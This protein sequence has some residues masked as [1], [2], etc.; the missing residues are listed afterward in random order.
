MDSL[1]S[2]LLSWPRGAAVAAIT[3]ASIAGS[4]AATALVVGFVHP[5]PHWLSS[6][7]IAVLIPSL[8]APLVS[9][10]V[11]GMM[12]DLERARAEAIK[13]A[14]TDQL[15]GTLNRRRFMEIAEAQFRPDAPDSARIAVILLDIDNFKMVN[16]VHGHR[17]GDM[18]LKNVA[19]LCAEGLR[20]ADHLARWGGEEFV[21]LLP[22]AGTL[23][24][25]GIAQRLCAAINGASMTV[26]GCPVRVSASIGIAST[27]LGVDQLERLLVMADRAM[28]EVKR[29]GKNN[30]LAAGSHHQTG[31]QAR[32]RRL[33]GELP[34]A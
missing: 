18:V 7:A 21:A 14:N 29:S 23:E 30:V 1:R 13:L 32:P 25:I 31:A 20:P 4:V 16:D 11:L 12:H 33:R 22:R 2:L 9:G 10:T 24:A 19:R 34:A 6:L 26:S 15:T 8:V 28:Y 3:G 17:A 5:H 27:E